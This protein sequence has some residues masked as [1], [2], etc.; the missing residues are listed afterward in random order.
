MDKNVLVAEV[1]CY[2]LKPRIFSHVL[3]ELTIVVYSGFQNQRLGKLLF[4]TLLTYIKDNRNDIIRVELVARESNAIEFYK[5]IGFV[6]EGRLEK[7]I[8]NKTGAFEADVPMAW[9]NRNFQNY[10]GN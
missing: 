2:K 1:H 10:S 3:S 6:V 8:N 4:T 9:F 5:N 7:R